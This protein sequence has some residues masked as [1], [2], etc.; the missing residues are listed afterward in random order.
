MKV[1]IL[2][3][4]PEIFQNFFSTSI[5]KKALEKKIIELNII[6]IRDFS[7]KKQNQVDDTL[8]GGGVGMVMMIEPIV[9]ALETTNQRNVILPTPRAP[10][11]KEEDAKR[12]SKG[13]EITIICGHYEGIDERI[14]HFIDEKYSIGDYV[15][16]SGDLSG[17]VIL[18]SILRLVEG[19]I[20]KESLEVESFEDNLLDY[21]VYTK[22]QDFRGL[23]VP[24]VY[25]SGNHKLI[26]Q[27][28]EESRIETTQKYR[29][30][31]LEKQNM[32]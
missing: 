32:F 17:L 26:R 31:L 25:L 2:T 28:R 19:V 13:D 22:P 14:N 24:E 3:I 21:E 11:F 1:N 6:D 9:K 16:S 23:K 30:D 10:M 8:Y 20:N 15:L 4:F 27:K 12:L 7:I 18:D 29:P 5:Y